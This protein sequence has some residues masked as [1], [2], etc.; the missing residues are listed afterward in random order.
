MKEKL[1]SRSHGRGAHIKRPATPVYHMFSLFMIAFHIRKGLNGLIGGAKV[2]W[3]EG[4]GILISKPGNAAGVTP[5]RLF[6]LLTLATIK[7][8]YS[9]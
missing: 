5:N 8:A 7:S 1:D 3:V 6:T 2:G 9:A 4:K